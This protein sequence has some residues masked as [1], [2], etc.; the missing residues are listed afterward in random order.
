MV[1]F[2][3]KIQAITREGEEAG[4]GQPFPSLK[5]S[6]YSWPREMEPCAEVEAFSNPPPHFVSPA[7]ISKIWQPVLPST[8]EDSNSINS[9]YNACFQGF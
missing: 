4:P 5:S 1:G 2:W 3:K 6:K 7:P 9:P 8:G